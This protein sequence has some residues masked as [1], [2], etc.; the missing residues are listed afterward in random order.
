MRHPVIFTE[1]LGPK[2]ERPLMQHSG[3]VEFLLSFAQLGD[4]SHRLQRAFRRRAGRTG[5]FKGSQA[6][7][8]GILSLVGIEKNLV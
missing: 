5:P 2:L 8:V 1:E 3:L 4:E 6:D 7:G